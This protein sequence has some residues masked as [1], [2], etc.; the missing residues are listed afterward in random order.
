MKA[1]LVLTS[2][3]DADFL[4]LTNQLMCGYVTLYG[5]EALDFCPAKALD[6]VVCAIVARCSG[7]PAASG[8]F[9]RFNGTTAELMRI[10]VLPEY[11][12]QGLGEQIVSALEDE[13][14]RCGF[15]RMVLVTGD[16]MQDALS[17]YKRLGYTH[18]ESYGPHKDDPI[19]VCMEKQLH[20][21]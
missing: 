16:D 3:D 11:R 14:L 12:R 6:E 17:L 13:A 8:A 2:K 7:N 9:R 4:R 18:M 20:S 10:Y 5:N 15:S 19:C 21:N 1:E